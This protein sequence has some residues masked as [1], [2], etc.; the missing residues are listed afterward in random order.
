MDGKD[1]KPKNNSSDKNSI[2]CA[3]DYSEKKISSSSSDNR[4]SSYHSKPVSQMDCD[5]RKKTADTVHSEGSIGSSDFH[6]REK[7]PQNETCGCDNSS[8]LESKGSQAK[9]SAT[10]NAD[11][12]GGIGG[13]SNSAFYE[14]IYDA[15]E[16][17][18]YNKSS[19]MYT[20]KL[21][22]IIYQKG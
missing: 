17:Q 21:I 19:N 10:N 12:F 14:R 2:V 6:H 8:S 3:H 11:L 22:L 1:G 20:G 7:V 13:K 9:A 5:S 15:I 18:T 16:V 4:S